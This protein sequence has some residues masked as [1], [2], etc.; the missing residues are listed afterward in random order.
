MISWKSILR[1]VVLIMAL[2][3]L[4]LPL[5]A[6]K[7]D[8]DKEFKTGKILQVQTAQAATPPRGYIEPTDV[9]HNP[10]SGVDTGSRSTLPASHFVNYAVLLDTGEETITLKG[11]FEDSQS[12]PDIKGIGEVQY[13]LRGSERVQV[14]DRHKRKF[15]FTVVKR[16]PK[17]NAA[18]AVPAASSTSQK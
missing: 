15:D 16:D 8:K 17:P 3:T 14:L 7:N 10:Y 5:Y 11:S 18:P 4:C 1:E 13:R 2:I 9:G 6:G 12:Q